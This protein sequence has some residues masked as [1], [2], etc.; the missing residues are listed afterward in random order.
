MSQGQSR[1]S[2]DRGARTRQAPVIGLA[3]MLAA[4][5]SPSAACMPPLA[6]PAA[7][8]S[9]CAE[10]VLQRTG[11]AGLYNR[12]LDEGATATLR[13]QWERALRTRIT[14]VCG[15]YAAALHRTA[16]WI[17]QTGT[18]DYALPPTAI[19]ALFFYNPIPR[20]NDAKSY[21]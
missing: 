1:R 13:P 2:R 9:R 4:A 7:D 21:C 16:A 17:R 10:T 20:A 14:P 15:T 3:M 18:S 6:R 11:Y 5:P 12:L 19:E 8:W